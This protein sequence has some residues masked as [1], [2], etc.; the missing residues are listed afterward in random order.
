[1]NKKVLQKALYK[2]KVLLL[3][4]L[5][6]SPADEGSWSYS[7]DVLLDLTLS[8]GNLLAG[9]KGAWPWPLAG[10]KKGS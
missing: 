10:S 5:A 1:M 7:C 6:N 2:R 9:G 8:P 4:I 3:L